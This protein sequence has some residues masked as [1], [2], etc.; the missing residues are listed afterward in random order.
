MCR[1]V[2]LSQVD[3]QVIPGASRRPFFP[4]QEDMHPDVGHLFS[5]S[6]EQFPDKTGE[7]HEDHSRQLYGEGIDKL[8]RNRF[9]YKFLRNIDRTNTLCGDIYVR[10]RERDYYHDL[11][12][13][14]YKSFHIFLLLLRFWDFLLFSEATSM[15]FYNMLKMCNKKW[16]RKLWCNNMRHI[17]G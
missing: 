2:R 9:Q 11:F 13:H 6:G 1:L 3:H 8:D 17:Y 16:K 4:F 15:P 5:A 10:F 12:K 7:G 14:L